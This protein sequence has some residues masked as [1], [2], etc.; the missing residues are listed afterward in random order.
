MQLK[1][2]RRVREGYYATAR[3]TDGILCNCEKG[4]RVRV[5]DLLAEHT[6]HLR[7][8]TPTGPQRLSREISRCAPTEHLDPTPF[9]DPNV[10]L[11]TSGIG[12]NFSEQSIWDGYVERL[13]RV[14]IAA[15]AF[16]V[17][18]AH[19]T[20]PPGL[21]LACTR[22][23]LPLLEVPTT[24]PLLKID[25]HVEGMLGA[26]RLARFDR[27][28]HLAD[29]CAKLA[30]QGAEISTLLA[31]IYEALDAPIAVF[32]AF[33]TLIAQYP[34]SLAWRAT[35]AMESQPDVLL[36]PLPMGL[37]TP[38]QLAVRLYR[39]AT[40][41]EALL[42]PVTSILA[43]QLN[44]SVSVDASSH[45]DMLRFAN[46]CVAWSEATRGDVADAFNEL[47]LSRRA[48]TTLLVAD[49]SGEHASA[50]WKLRV[51]LHDAFHDV[52]LSELDTQL[53]ALAQFPRE[54][55]AELT[56]RFLTIQEGLPLVLSVPT[57]TIDEL[58]IALVHALD[59]VR[60]VSAPVVA[61]ALGLSAVVAAAAGRGAREAAAR[62]LAPLLEHDEHRTTELMPTLRVW[63]RNDAQPSRTCEELFIHRNS[64]SY[65]LRRIEQLLGIS[66]DT[67]DGRATC[68]MALRLVE[69][70][71]Y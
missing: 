3:E 50:A 36:V 32:D 59:L 23:D 68:L 29:K 56:R 69:F 7:L 54:E 28:W 11:L 1:L 13:T 71:P 8:E 24:V 20:L 12:M 18:A 40:E 44:R 37:S 48:E 64:L 35:T 49:L 4:V 63:L 21:V 45:Q 25:Q 43:L 51:A 19:K 60:H 61:P 38:C 42:A 15:L 16:A 27:G 57:H 67:L 5:A 17:G 33:D 9:L 34:E 31:A 52:R 39:P 47:G 6:L 14:P 26:E 53:V 55:A 62:F 22:H 2:R 41:V 70:E 65:R 30:S 66:L 58:R 46:R 10:L